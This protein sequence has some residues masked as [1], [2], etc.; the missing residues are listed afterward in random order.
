[1]KLV[2]GLPWYS[3]PD[4][5]TGPLYMDMMMYF[6]ALRERTILKDSVSYDEWVKIRDK[7]PPLDESGDVNG[8]PTDLDYSRLGRLEIAII[9]HSRT[10]LVGRARESIVDAA[11]DW[12][13]DYLFWWDADMKFKQS[14]FLSLFRNNVPVVGALAFTARHPIYPVIFGINKEDD[15][16]YKSHV[17]FDYPKDTLV[18]NEEVGGELAMG[19]GC[20]LIDM[21]VFNVI[22]KPWFYST[23]T[24]EDWFFCNRCAEYGIKRFVDTRVKT[25]HKEHLPRWANEEMY[26]ILKEQAPKVYDDLKEETSKPALVRI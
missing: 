17:M 14:A 25:E 4:E 23:G 26:Q 6:G 1:M 5:T 2:I 11:L 10:S 21:E 9:D 3:G 8:E 22:P 12:G 24:G 7:L 18:G 16:V 13:A 20:M 15:D 19:S